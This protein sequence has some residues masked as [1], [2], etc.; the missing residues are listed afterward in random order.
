MEPIIKL[1]TSDRTIFVNA[2]CIATIEPTYKLP[3]TEQKKG[4]TCI[5]LNFNGEQHYVLEDVN[6]ILR[7]ISQQDI[8]ALFL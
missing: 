5:T 7:L 2:K 6:E 3:L 8:A 4:K 1:H